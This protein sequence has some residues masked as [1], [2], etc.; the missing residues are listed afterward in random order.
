MGLIVLFKAGMVGGFGF[1]IAVGVAMALLTPS[2]KSVQDA[3]IQVSKIPAFLIF[4]VVF[5]IGS[6]WAYWYFSSGVTVST[7]AELERFTIY[8]CLFSLVPSVS[9][10]CGAFSYYRAAQKEIQGGD[11]E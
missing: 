7:P 1:I 5:A 9:I 4:L 2:P 10:I 6:G 11:T 3:S 8:A